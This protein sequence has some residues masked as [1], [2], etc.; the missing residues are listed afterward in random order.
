MTR[1]QF[2]L[3]SV[4]ENVDEIWSFGATTNVSF[5][6]CTAT[7]HMAIHMNTSHVKI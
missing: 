5:Y 6:F 4:I 7:F 1:L 3:S 2:S